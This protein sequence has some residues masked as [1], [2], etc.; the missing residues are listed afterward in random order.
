MA[1]DR[2]EITIAPESAA[3]A[4]AGHAD[5]P[6]TN[7]EARGESAWTIAHRHGLGTGKLLARNGLTTRSVLHPG[8]VLVLDAGDP[9]PA[10]AQVKAA[11]LPGE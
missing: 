11:A 7:V 8:M 10:N 2:V 9:P 1:G 5:Q 3:P 6:R 4:E